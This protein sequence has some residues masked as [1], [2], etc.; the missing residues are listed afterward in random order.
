METGV[1]F[2]MPGGGGQKSPSYIAGAVQHPMGCWRTLAFSFGTT[3][4]G[5]NC[6]QEKQA[7]EIRI[8]QKDADESQ[9]A[10]NKRAR[11]GT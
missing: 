2:I 10:D 11:A 7:E 1:Y 3:H 8:F 4:G 5:E 6:G 9:T